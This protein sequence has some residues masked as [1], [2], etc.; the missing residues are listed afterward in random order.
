M[1]DTPTYPGFPQRGV[2]GSESHYAYLARS[3]LYQQLAGKAAATI[4][5]R[6][7]A[8]TP[9]PRF[10]RPPE[11][12]RI[13]EKR[14]RSAGLSG[15]KLASLRDLAGRVERGALKLSHIARL[16]DERIIERLVEV[17]GIG[18]WTVQMFLMF[19]LGR[20]DVMPTGD[21]GVQEGLRRLDGLHERPGP[22]TVL[23]RSEVWAPLRTVAAWTLWRLADEGKR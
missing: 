16:G 3:I 12:L 4:H 10:P 21:L 5:G 2:P 1:K 18:V 9:G 13:S 20:L 8:L 15:N 19:R 23:A 17:R 22:A 14:L 7:C 11:L 6:V